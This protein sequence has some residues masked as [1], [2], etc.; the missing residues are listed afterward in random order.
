M[1]IS[2][3]NQ[4]QTTRV[5]YRSLDVDE[6]HWSSLHDVMLRSHLFGYI[7]VSKVGE[8]GIGG[9]CLYLGSLQELVAADGPMSRTG[10]RQVR[11]K[12]RQQRDSQSAASVHLET[13]FLQLSLLFASFSHPLP[14]SLTR[15]TS[16]LSSFTASVPS[17][18]LDLYFQC[19]LGSGGRHGSFPLLS[20]QTSKRDSAS[21]A[22]NSG[23]LSA[24]WLDAGSFSYRYGS[25]N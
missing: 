17:G 3:G 1:L 18:L 16:I 2:S 5:F 20:T 10:K 21:S 19:R 23:R 15:Q 11:S 25:W 6:L 24:C 8:Q 12:L 13:W 7:S 9:E 22:P 4:V 14:C